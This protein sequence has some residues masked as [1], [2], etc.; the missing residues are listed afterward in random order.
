MM[1]FLILSA[2]L[3]LTACGGLPKHREQQ[4]SSNPTLLIQ[5]AP[6]GSAVFVDGAFVT[7]ISK[8]KQVIN[9]EPGTHKVVIS[10]GSVTFYERDVFL[11]GNTQK[12]IDL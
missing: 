10:K 7:Q 3:F 9:V 4:L 6:K 1:R 12:K 8:S 11:Q 2:M 5:D